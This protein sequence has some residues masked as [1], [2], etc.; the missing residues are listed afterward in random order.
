MHKDSLS[1]ALVLTL[2]ISPIHNA[3]GWR[4]TGIIKVDAKCLGLLLGYYLF[5]FVILF[6]Y[7]SDVFG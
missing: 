2:N 7:F 3:P 1:G 6:R 4:D 5:L